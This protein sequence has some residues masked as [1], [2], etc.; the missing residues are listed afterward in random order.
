MGREV[1]YITTPIFYANDLP[2]IGHG[3]VGVATDFV[4]RYHRLRGEEVLHL[5]G[6]DEHGLNVKRIAEAHGVSPQ[7][8]VDDLEPKWREVWARLDVAYDDYIRTT[9]PRHAAAVAKLLETVHG[10]GRDDIYLGTYEGLYC[11]SCEA[12]YVED[13]L[14][15]GGLCPVHERPVEHL[16]EE[17]YFFRLSAY[18][19][20][21]LAHYEAHP[22]AIEPETRRNEILSLV[23]GGLQDFSISR[24][25]MDWGIPI[26]WDPKHVTYV[27]FDALTNYI[28]AAGYES[29]AER[30]SRVWP[31][32]IHMVGKDIIRFHAVYWPAMLM[33]A[34]V[35]LPLQVWAHGYLTVG[36]KKMSKTNATGIHPF[37]LID[38]F[39]T[40]SYRYY[41]M[42]EMR[43]GEDGNFSWESMVERHNADLANGLGNLASRVL[44]MLGSN[45]DG[46]VPPP[47]VE[48]CESDLPEVT[49]DALRRYDE[50][51]LT[52]RPQPALVAVWD[53]VARANRYLVEKAPWKFAADD[54]RRDELGSILYASVETLRILAIAIQPI[55]PGAAERLGE[56]LGVEEPLGSQRL[57]ASGA[58]GGLAP[59]T[60]AAKG[61]SLFPRLEAD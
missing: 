48:R 24:T 60:V 13:D 15:P 29:D 26:P 45:F 53:I 51:M 54:T 30:F 41:F 9:E 31:A 40:D 6:T 17:N 5:T 23:R 4:A 19:D 32:N 34:G 25:T 43:F 8:W 39:G 50:H 7:Q 1:F 38:R 22:E 21:L 10:N 33:A 55:M 52:V 27:W 49:A 2:H 58:W 18:Q 14:L 12:Y 44:A 46:K 16:A 11:V 56:Q 36:G 57:P 37:E 47:T 42:R 61:A 3:Y 59:G 20:R 28:T 35:E